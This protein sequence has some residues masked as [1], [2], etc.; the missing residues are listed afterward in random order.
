M[1]PE[2]NL[3]PEEP[4]GEHSFFTEPT[5]L[6]PDVPTPL[7]PIIDPKLSQ[8]ENLK[9]QIRLG[10]FTADQLRNAL[11]P[12]IPRANANARFSTLMGLVRESL[13]EEDSC[14]PSLDPD[15]DKIYRMQPITKEN[16]EPERAT[17]T[18]KLLIQPLFDSNFDVQLS[19]KDKEKPPITLSK[20][21]LTLLKKILGSKIPFS[22]ESL[23][24][25]MALQT[26]SD[27]F[28]KIGGFE[29]VFNSLCEKMNSGWNIA[30]TINEQDEVIVAG[31]SA[32]RTPLTPL[33]RDIDEENEVIYK[34]KQRKRRPARRM[35]NGSMTL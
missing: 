6:T 12:G 21:E 9:S 19:I 26:D 25:K 27:A 7:F 29:K 3:L 2:F 5:P 8:V 15:S 28:V 31:K 10:I 16:A 20:D 1:N 13:L 23:E 34:E 33:R 14:I 11:F 24:M 35:K 4:T 17:P 18:Q 22:R 32:P 30:L